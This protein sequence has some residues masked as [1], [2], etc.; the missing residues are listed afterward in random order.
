MGVLSAVIEQETEEALQ[1][2]INFTEGQLMNLR[3]ISL[4]E[5]N[6]RLLVEAVD[7]SSGNYVVS[8]EINGRRVMKKSLQ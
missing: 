5:G 6:K 3:I 4:V 7:L 1:R 8:T 2:K